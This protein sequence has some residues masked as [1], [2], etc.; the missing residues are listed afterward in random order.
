MALGFLGAEVLRRH[1]QKRISQLFSHLK[2][3]PGSA[4]T[5]EE[6]RSPAE[7]MAHSKVSRGGVCAV[8]LPSGEVAREMDTGP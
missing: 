7:L 4:T 1:R 8:E 3:R 5:L 2:S 6:G